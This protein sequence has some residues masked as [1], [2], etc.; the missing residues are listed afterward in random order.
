MGA[1][2]SLGVALGFVALTRAQQQPP[3]VNVQFHGFQDSRGVTVLSPTVDLSR[4]FS[5][6][7]GMRARFGVDAISAASDSCIRCHPQGADNSRVFANV[8]AIKP[9]RGSKVSVGGEYSQEKFYRATTLLS[10]IS[11]EV[12]EGNTTVA[13]G[14]SFSL[15]QPKLHPSDD[16]ERQYAQSAYGSVTQ[17]VTKSTAV[18]VGYELGRVTGYQA[19]PFLRALVNG[20]RELGN[21]PDERTRHSI[22]ARVRQALPGDTYFEADYRRYFDSWE[23]KSNAFSVGLSRY[24]T[25]QLMLGGAYR[26][27][28]QTGAYFWAPSYTGTPGLFTADFRLAPFTSNLYTGKL[29]FTP[30]YSLLG[31]PEG[32]AV[33][34]Q[35]ELYSASNPFKAAIFTSGLRVPLPHK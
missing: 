22:S 2:V 11:R 9:F 5:D 21:A 24:V 26:R 17:T 7:L 23:I 27:Y 3:E 35:Y 10:S 29:V 4:D 34:L 12:N 28:A 6:R 13:G 14:F 25:P 32:A 19:N 18:Q 1:A 20:V 16:V 15:N 30:T 31:L 8:S 33:T